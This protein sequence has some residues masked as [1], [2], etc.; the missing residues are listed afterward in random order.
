MT[1]GV[2]APGAGRRVGMG[3][4]AIRELLGLKTEWSN[5]GPPDR[6]TSTGRSRIAGPSVH[7]QT[8]TV[9]VERTRMS[10]TRTRT[11]GKRKEERSRSE[12]P[13]VPS[14]REESGRYFE[15]VA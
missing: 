7:D 2:A 9:H 14:R 3:H 1:P 11:R 12:E 5:P 10:P 15:Y 13:F 8:G 6:R 4:V